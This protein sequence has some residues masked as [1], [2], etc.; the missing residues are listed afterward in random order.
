MTGHTGEL[1]RVLVLIGTRPEAIKLAVVIH[2]IRSR[3][4]ACI[5]CSTGQHK[6]MLAQALS[7]FGIVPDITLDT[8]R[9]GQGLGELTAS[10]IRG[11][12]AVVD[13]YRP[14]WIVVQGDTTTSMAGA[15]VGFYRRIPVAHVEAGLRTGRLDAPFPE[16]FNRRVAG[17]VARMHFAPTDAA[18]RNLLRE[19]V[20]SSAVMVTGNTVIDSLLWVTDD[21]RRDPPRLPPEVEMLEKP[22][23]RIILVTCH[24]RESFGKGLRDVCMALRDLAYRYPDD[25]IVYPLHLNPNVERPVRELIGHVPGITLTTPLG[26]RE[27][28]RLMS[29]AAIVLT[30]SGGIQEEAPSLHKPVLVMRSTT[31]RQEGVETGGVRLVGTD[32][33]TIVEGVSTILDSPEIY[34]R[35][36]NGRNP[37]GDGKAAIR[38]ADTLLGC[39]TSE[40]MGEGGIDTVSSNTELR[41]ATV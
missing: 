16:E 19:G 1:A 6:E 2:E 34:A 36:A 14:S 26:Y 37:Y 25:R 22:G 41:E 17:M 29:M 23:R 20:P 11:I 38:I 24:R 8:M 31:E 3:N 35:M 21:I 10:L 27:F 15:M 39:T 4:F 32:P 40:M 5:V 9:G 30:D 13:A 18:R 12:D 28:V 7:A 33:E